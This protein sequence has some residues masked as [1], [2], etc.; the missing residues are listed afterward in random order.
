[1]NNQSEN[2]TISQIKVALSDPHQASIDLDHPET[3]HE[4]RD[5]FEIDSMEDLDEDNYGNLK[6]EGPKTGFPASLKP[7]ESYAA[8]FKIHVKDSLEYNYTMVGF[9]LCNCISCAV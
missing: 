7:L 3:Y 8:L 2:M 1:M 6:I 9:S 4:D 5:T